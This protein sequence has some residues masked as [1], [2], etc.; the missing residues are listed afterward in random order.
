MTGELHEVSQAIGGLQAETAALVK[1]FDRH[2][3]DDDR[4]HGENIKAIRDLTETLRP[5]AD[6][7]RSAKPDLEAMKLSRAKIAGISSVLL[8]FAGGAVWLL[9][10]LI[11]KALTWA[12][13]GH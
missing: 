13:G 11:D 9:E 6:W 3:D 12:M 1:S 7:A 5:I 2:C 10:K 8:L 4:R